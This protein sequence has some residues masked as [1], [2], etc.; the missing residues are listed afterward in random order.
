M[1][2]VPDTDSSSFKTSVNEAFGAVL[3]GRPW[4]PLVA[5]LCDAKTLRGLPMLRQM[6]DYLIGCDYDANF[7]QQH[8]AVNDASGKILDLYIAMSEDVI[9]WSELKDVPPFTPKLEAS[10]SYDPYLDGPC[11]D[12]GGMTVDGKDPDANR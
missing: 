9:S 6:E 1:I 2:V 10:W 3:C 12:T 5:R 4:R 11:L 7:L 8:C